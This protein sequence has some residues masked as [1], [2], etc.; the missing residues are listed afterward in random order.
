MTTWTVLFQNDFAE[1]FEALDDAVQ[2]ELL[3]MVEHLET[4]GP[5]AK[6]PQVDTLK[7]SKLTNKR[8][9]VRRR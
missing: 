6:R 9:S 5:T 2:I 1:E 3:A 8:V 7:G 4:F